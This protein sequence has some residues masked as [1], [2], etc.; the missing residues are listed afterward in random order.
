MKKVRE[1]PLKY[2]TAIILMPI[3]SIV[4]LYSI[5][6][7]VAVAENQ[8]SMFIYIVSITGIVYMNIVMFNFFESYSTQIKLAFMESVA[9]REAENY[10]S[11]KIAYQEM[12]KL[13]HDFQNEL[14][15]INDLIE[16]KKY[17]KAEAYISELLV[18]I[19][20]SAAVCYTG[21][22]AIDSL[23]N[24]KIKIA[25]R[26][27]IRF[28]VK[29]KLYSVLEVNSMEMCR[30]IG[31][32]LDNAIEACCN[33]TNVERFIFLSFK[34]VDENVLLEI[35]N[36]SEYTDT[37]DLTSSKSDKRLHGYGVQS[38]CSSAERIGGTICF[39]YED[40]VFTFKLL[41]RN[42]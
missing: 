32:A 8:Y 1:L 38:I 11:F 19:E 30:I 37:N 40:G 17:D 18:F 6:I 24:I 26:Y 23:V 42:N 27:N 25:E 7:S 16:N 12:K 28:T 39:K 35:S 5:F 20:K 33:I 3:M 4:I 36:S 2:W 22:E 41:M 29:I 31:N 15:I 10:R 14:A 13:K 9:E 34:E 21:N